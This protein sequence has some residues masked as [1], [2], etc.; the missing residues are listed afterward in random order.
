MCM[1]QGEERDSSDE[2]WTNAYGAMDPISQLGWRNRRCGAEGPAEELM[3]DV[4]ESA[5][6]VHSNAMSEMVASRN[7]DDDCPVSANGTVTASMSRHGGVSTST[8]ASVEV[9]LEGA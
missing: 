5:D 3:R 8:A 1:A 9:D 7:T 4:L 6:M 2:E